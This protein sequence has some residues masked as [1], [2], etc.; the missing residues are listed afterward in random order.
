[1]IKFF[2]RIRYKL[3]IENRFTRYLL[4]AIGEIVLVVFGILIALEI[5][6]Q[7][8]LRKNELIVNMA[9]QETQS[10][11]L[12]DIIEA[13]ENLDQFLVAYSTEKKIF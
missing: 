6:N 5:N 1:M 10:N 11:L 2:R 3:L 7:N 8:E 9:L 13:Q 4:Y 12:S